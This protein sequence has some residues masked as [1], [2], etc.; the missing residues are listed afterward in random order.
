MKELLMVTAMK[1]PEARLLEELQDALITHRLKG[2]EESHNK[3]KLMVVMLSTKYAM[4]G[5]SVPDALKDLQDVEQGL[6][7][8]K[9]MNGG[10]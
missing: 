2:T 9:R 3:L 8:A 10:N 4:E 5:T 7:I 1:T 6:A